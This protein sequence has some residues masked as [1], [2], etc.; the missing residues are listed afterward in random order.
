MWIAYYEAFCLLP[1]HDR[2]DLL[3]ATIRLMQIVLSDALPQ[4]L[5]EDE[6]ALK[7]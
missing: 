7:V 2:S 6:K 5:T 3:K 4:D 1:P